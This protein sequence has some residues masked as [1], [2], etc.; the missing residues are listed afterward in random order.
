[1]MSACHI[2]DITVDNVIDN[3]KLTIGNTSYILSNPDQNTEQGEN[4]TNI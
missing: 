3:R 1:M 4:L 2:I